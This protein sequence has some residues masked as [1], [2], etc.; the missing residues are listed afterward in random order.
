MGTVLPLRPGSRLGL[1]PSSREE[2][3][4]LC[5]LPAGDPLAEHPEGR[6]RGRHRRLSGIEVRARFDGAQELLV[7]HNRSVER[8]PVLRWA[9]ENKVVRRVGWTECPALPEF[10]PAER[11]ETDKNGSF[12]LLVEAGVA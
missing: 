1:P 2:G 8:D 5:G 7:V 6:L 4:E 9:C 12:E 3:G 11:T 10:V